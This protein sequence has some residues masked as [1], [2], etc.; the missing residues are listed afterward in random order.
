[1]IDMMIPVNDMPVNKPDLNEVCNRLLSALNI[2]NDKNHIVFVYDALRGNLLALEYDLRNSVISVTYDSEYYS[3][4][5]GIGDILKR[6]RRYYRREPKF[7]IQ[8]CNEGEINK[9]FRR[10]S[11]ELKRLDV[12]AP[13]NPKAETDAVE[14]KGI[15]YEFLRISQPA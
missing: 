7:I 9:A 5:G 13:K 10:M 2:Q 8:H 4:H 6:W 15:F 14:F 11:E 1:M 3:L 12:T